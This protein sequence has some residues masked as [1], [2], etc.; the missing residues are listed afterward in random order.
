MTPA[1]SDSLAILIGTLKNG[2][3]DAIGFIKSVAP[4]L[5][6]MAQQ[7]VRTEM[8]MEYIWG[9]IGII[10]LVIGS[11]LMVSINGNRKKDPDFLDSDRGYFTGLM[12]AIFIVAG[13][14]IILINGHML[15]QRLSNP[16][17]YAL[18]IIRTTA[19]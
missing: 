1:V 19:R 11:L 3:T 12:T 10:S 5:W 6:R 14:I 4:D 16:D 2:V 7:Q 15:V 13:L 9:G 17:W 8:R 18:K